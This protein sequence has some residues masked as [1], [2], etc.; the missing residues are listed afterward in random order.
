MM[1]S[2]LNFAGMGRNR[3]HS[4]QNLSHPFSRYVLLAIE[5]RTDIFLFGLGP[6]KVSRLQQHLLYM[7]V[8]LEH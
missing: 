5:F 3:T 8:I 4:R 1:G 6:E 7:W 2:R